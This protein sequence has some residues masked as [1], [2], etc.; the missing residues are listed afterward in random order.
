MM[1]TV[2]SLVDEEVGQERWYFEP[3]CTEGTKY[4]DEGQQTIVSSMLFVDMLAQNG[5]DLAG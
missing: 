5:N 2:E 4:F 3:E 1:I